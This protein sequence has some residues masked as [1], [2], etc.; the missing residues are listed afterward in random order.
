MINQNPRDVLIK[1]KLLESS[2]LKN[3]KNV[4]PKTKYQVIS[5]FKDIR[6]LVKYRVY[7]P[8]INVSDDKTQF[9]CPTCKN[10][11][12]AIDGSTVDDF[13]ICQCCGQLFKKPFIG[14]AND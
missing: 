7:A 3:G 8:P 6:E 2:M 13:D 14:G 1:L 12:E 4:D 10:R 5:L 11:M 9:T